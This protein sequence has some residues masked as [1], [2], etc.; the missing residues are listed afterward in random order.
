[1]TK[2]TKK[3]LNKIINESVKRVL[4]EMYGYPYYGSKKINVVSHGE[5]SDPELEA[6]GY[7]V[8]INTIEELTISEYRNEFNIG[9]FV[10]FENFEEQYG[11]WVLEN[12]AYIISLIEEYGEKLE[13]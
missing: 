11:E 4:N 7:V 13:D 5:W 6:N 3:E 12:E 8:N 10:D 1:M 2:I 9:R